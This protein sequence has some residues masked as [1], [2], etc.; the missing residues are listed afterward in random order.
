MQ[1]RK[2][3]TRSLRQ[4]FYAPIVIVT[5]PSG[6]P[7]HLRF[8]LDKPTEANALH[9]SAHKKTASLNRPI[10]LGHFQAFVI[11]SEEFASR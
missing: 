9:A 3:I 2:L 11:L 7:E 4:N 1:P 8:T 10:T 5:N 6:N